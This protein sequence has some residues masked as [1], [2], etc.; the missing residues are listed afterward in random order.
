MPVSPEAKER[1]LTALRAARP[2][3]S[4][5]MFGGLGLYHDGI[6]MGV[7]DNDRLFFKIDPETEPDYVAR[8]MAPWSYDGGKTEQPYRELPEDVLNE[9]DVCGKW[10]DESRD[11]AIRRKGRTKV[12]RE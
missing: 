12:K 4:K 8:G 5:P 1:F 6:F 2:I 7:V 11:A 3:E 9:P 10:L